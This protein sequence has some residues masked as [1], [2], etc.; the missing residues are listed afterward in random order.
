MLRA[1][2]CDRF[3]SITHG[4]LEQEVTFSV[5]LSS[6]RPGVLEGM[7]SRRMLEGFCCLEEVVVEEG[8][9]CGRKR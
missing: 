3:L 2:E 5:D 4:N 8:G 7:L 6:G 9:G 1:A